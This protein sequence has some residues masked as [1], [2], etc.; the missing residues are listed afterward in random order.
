MVGLGIMGKPMARDLLK[1]EHPLF[2]HNRSQSSVDE[3]VAAGATAASSA[4]EVAERTDVTITM[5]LDTPDVE[6]A[7][8]GAKGVL[9]G[10]RAGH[11]LID[12]STISPVVTR[13]ISATASERGVKML[14]APVS[15][16]DKGAIAGTLSIMVGGKAE[17]FERARP[18][19]ECM[20]KTVVHCGPTGAGQIVKACNQVVV[21]IVIE[22]VSEALV[23]GSKAGVR[24]DIILQVLNGG[25]GSEPG[26]GFT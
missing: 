17:D 26:N 18:I 20:G 23:L 19:L 16:G 12:M 15:R 3:L 9:D 8:M 14:D 13:R 11:L 21:A 10:A 2:V 24:P 6:A 7:V 22:A 4:Q 1:A 25:V 5:L